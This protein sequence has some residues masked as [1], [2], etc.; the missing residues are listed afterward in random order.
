MGGGGGKGGSQTQQV[1]IPQWIADPAS[2]N[3][4]RAEQAQRIGYMPYY[5]PDVAAFTPMQEAAMNANIAAAEAFGLVQ[6]GTLSPTGG[7]GPGTEYAGGV[8]GYGSA[9]L[10]EQALAEA[11]RKDP[12]AFQQYGKLFV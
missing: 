1:Q 4:A 2:R 11:A 6:P 7:M 12:A 5:G 8:R 3:L 10:Y 9:N